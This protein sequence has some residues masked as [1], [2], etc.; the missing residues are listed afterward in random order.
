MRRVQWQDDHR[1]FAAL[2]L[3]DRGGVRQSNLVPLIRVIFDDPLVIV[4]ANLAVV[5]VD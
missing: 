4:D 5:A 1:V 3:M 2:A